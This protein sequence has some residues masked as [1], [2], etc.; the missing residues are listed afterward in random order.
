MNNIKLRKDSPAYFG[1]IMVRGLPFIR[2]P[3]HTKNELGDIAEL[4]PTQRKQRSTN[5]VR[6]RI[7][8]ASRRRNR[9]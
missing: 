2:K 1:N 5:R 3:K 4:T 7:A 8:K 9:A 6:N